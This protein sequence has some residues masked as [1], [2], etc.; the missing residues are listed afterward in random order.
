MKKISLFG[1]AALC[2]A[3]MMTGCQSVNNSGVGRLTINPDTVGPVTNFRPIYELVS[4]EPVTGTARVHSV[5]GLFV[6][7]N[8]SGMADYTAS[9]A[10]DSSA[11]RTFLNAQASA[12]TGAQSNLFT[13]AKGQAAKAAFYEACVSNNCDA[14]VAA[15]YTI[16]TTSYVLYDEYE[17]TVTGWPV[18]LTGVEPVEPVPYYINGRGKLQVLPRFMN[19]Q[20]VFEGADEGGSK[21][22]EPFTGAE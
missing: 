21:I 22:T 2:A 16:K 13:S 9:L 17:V 18:K 8:T 20:K 6:W 4:K 10:E 15:K 5:C 1:A 7:S 12:Y 19:M 14:I 11:V 3:L